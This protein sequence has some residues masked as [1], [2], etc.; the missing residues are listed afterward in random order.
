MR[1]ALLPAGTW[2]G[3]EGWGAPSWSGGQVWGD[4]GEA[5][6]GMPV[7]SPVSR[8]ERQGPALLCFAMG[9]PVACGG[10]WI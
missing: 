4:R 2:T 3:G 7:P 1:A 8:E 6:R 10:T 9:H 5:W